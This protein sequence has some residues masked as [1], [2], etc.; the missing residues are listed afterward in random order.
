MRKWID[1]ATED[2]AGSRLSADSFILSSEDTRRWCNSM[3][4]NNI[5]ALLPFQGNLSAICDDR[6]RVQGLIDIYCLEDTQFLCVLN[7]VDNDWFQQRFSMYMLLDDIEQE[8]LSNSIFHLCGPNSEHILQS[9]G[10]KT[11]NKETHYLDNDGTHILRKNRFGIEGFDV[12]TNEINVLQEKLLENGLNIIPKEGFEAIRI[13]NCRPKWPD[14]GT[15]KTMI[16]ELGLN[17]ECCAF[18]KG[19]YIGQEIINRIDVKGLINKKI[20]KLSIEG[21]ANIGDG[22]SIDGK[23]V[24]NITSITQLP[25]GQI[26]LSIIKK[27]A[28]KKGQL[29]N[30]SSGGTATV[31]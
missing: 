25:D 27:R 29:L 20:H 19:C 8:L 17:E 6:G 11:P 23:D 4:S 24:G 2:S 16:H 5:R 3:F 14:D 31:L 30:I 1:F 12:I 15:D 7:G 9:S 13:I 10:F 22:L 18:D 26:A 21:S 28:W